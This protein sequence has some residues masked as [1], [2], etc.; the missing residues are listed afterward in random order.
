MPT[1][2]TKDITVLHVNFG[3][4]LASCHHGAAVLVLS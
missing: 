3:A 2:P 1:D 4:K